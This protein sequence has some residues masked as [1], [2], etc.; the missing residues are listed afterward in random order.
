M[1]DR[2]RVIDTIRDAFGSNEYP[3]DPFLQG[4]FEGCEPADGV[5]QFVG[6]E[7]WETVDPEIID[8]AGA[9]NFFSEAA[10]RFYMPAYLIA[11]LREQLVREDPVFHLVHGFHDIAVEVPTETGTFVRKTGGSAFVNPR[12]YGAMTWYDHGRQRLSIFTREEAQA[13]VAYLKH[14]RAAD[15][16]GLNHESIDVALDAYWLDRASNA[17]P[18]E[19]LMAH[20]E[21]EERSCAASTQNS[22]FRG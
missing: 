10:F 18:R 17:P 9:L 14:R 19:D 11:D 20:L 22:I 13:I 5:G 3:G 12:R 7:D 8:G 16:H 15:P 6:Q 1:G 2:D 4:S 21:E